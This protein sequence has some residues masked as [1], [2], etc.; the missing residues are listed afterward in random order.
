MP[1]GGAKDGPGYAKKN[2]GGQ[3]PLPTSQAYDNLRN[4]YCKLFSLNH[5][6]R[7]LM[8]DRAHSIF[9]TFVAILVALLYLFFEG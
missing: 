4:S 2:L 5:C 6:Y 9:S 8:R 1:G 7:L 3:L